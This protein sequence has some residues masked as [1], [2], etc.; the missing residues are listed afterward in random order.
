MRRSESRTRMVQFNGLETIGQ[1][2]M[3][4]AQRVTMEALRPENDPVLQ[5]ILSPEELLAL[6]E[7]RQA[8]QGLI[9]RKHSVS[10]KV[11]KSEIKELQYK[12]KERIIESQ[13][14]PHSRIH[15]K[16]ERKG[17]EPTTSFSNSGERGTNAVPLTES[18]LM[19]RGVY[20]QPPA[21]VSVQ[22]SLIEGRDV[23]WEPLRESEYD[24]QL[25]VS[26]TLG[27]NPDPHVEVDDLLEKKFQERLANIHVND[28]YIGDEEDFC[29]ACYEGEDSF[30]EETSKQKVQVPVPNISEPLEKK[31]IKKRRR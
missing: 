17:F 20:L 19:Q 14:L 29:G 18:D 7:V 6:S 28:E 3:P 12:V 16:R 11:T 5:Q 26:K 25:L 4:P 27:F 9:P 23:T 21:K 15:R 30:T 13:P 8:Q 24:P 2:I 1:G 10:D 22:K 31:T